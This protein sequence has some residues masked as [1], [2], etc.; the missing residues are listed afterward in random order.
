MEESITSMHYFGYQTIRDA[1]KSLSPGKNGHIL[2]AGSGFGGSTRYWV[3]QLETENT[4]VACEYNS[5]FDE[6][7][8]IATKSLDKSVSSRVTHVCDDLT[9]ARFGGPKFD[10]VYSILVFLHIPKK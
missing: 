10:G 3:E 4:I 8:S 7:S 2:D 9:T 5:E 1:Q 6:L